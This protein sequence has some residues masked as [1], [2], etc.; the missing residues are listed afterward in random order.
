[1]QQR[2][3]LER[4]GDGGE[5]TNRT[6]AASSSLDVDDEHPGE[7]ACACDPAERR[8]GALLLERGGRGAKALEFGA[9]E[10]PR[11]A[12]FGLARL[13]ETDPVLARLRAVGSGSSEFGFDA[14]A[15]WL[16]VDRSFRV[17]VRASLED[18]PTQDPGTLH[19]EAVSPY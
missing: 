8:V 13:I 10:R 3:D 5:D 11:V 15:F 4:V 2:G 17:E 6:A 14:E 9:D 16:G 12:D 1:M 7:Q 18:L 19:V